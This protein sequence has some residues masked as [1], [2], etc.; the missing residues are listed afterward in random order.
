[1]NFELNEE[2]LAFQDSARKF[3]KV[4]LGPNAALWDEQQIFPKEAL[5][6]AGDL[7]FMAMY[8]PEEDYGIG[9][10]RL[11]ASIILEELSAG[12]TSTAAYISIHN[13]AINMISKYGTAAMKEQWSETL[14]CGEKLASYC[15][16]EPGAGSDAASLRTSATKIGDSY[17]LNGSKAFI[18]GGG[19]TDMLVVMARTGSSGPKGV[20]AFAVPADSKGI[21][22]GK[23]ESKMGWNSQ[24]TR[25]ITFDEVE[26]SEK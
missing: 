5:R 12:C 21:S 16:T 20:S 23:K 19:D 14:A 15:L 10:S 4:Q 26:I 3:S 1:M 13:M 22:Y 24:P 7:G 25:A 17:L 18:S 8:V 11:D 2:Q 6:A 9:L